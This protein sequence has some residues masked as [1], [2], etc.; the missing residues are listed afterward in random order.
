MLSMEGAVTEM[1]FQTLNAEASMR[2]A[3]VI[4]IVA[5]FLIARV[6]RLNQAR[7]LVVALSPMA[8][9][10]ALNVTLLHG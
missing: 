6:A 1:I 9:V 7:A 5:F 3:S 2:L 10:L 8:L 4:L